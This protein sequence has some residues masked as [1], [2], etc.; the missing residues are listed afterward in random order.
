MTI[1]IQTVEFDRALLDASQSVKIVSTGAS[2]SRL[3]ISKAYVVRRVQR[4]MFQNIEIVL[5]ITSLLDCP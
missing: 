5:L 2:I 1:R 3:M 4:Y